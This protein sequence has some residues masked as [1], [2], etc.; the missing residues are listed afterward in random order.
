M[1][2]YKYSSFPFLSLQSGTQEVVGSKVEVACLRAKGTRLNLPVA[3]VYAL[4]NLL[5]LLL[6]LPLPQ[7]V[8]KVF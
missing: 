1:A 7:Y 8:C 5:C 2:L 4:Y 3:V 6:L